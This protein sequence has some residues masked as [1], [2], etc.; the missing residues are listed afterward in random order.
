MASPLNVGDIYLLGRLAFK[1][2]SA[3]SRG[4]KS[5]PQEFREVENQLYSLSAALQA[6]RNEIQNGLS[7]DS[8]SLPGAFK[9]RNGGDEDVVGRIVESCGETLKHLEAIVEKYS[10]IG[11][12]SDGSPASSTFRRWNEG[13]KSGWKAILWTK[14]GGDLMTLRSNLAVHTN[15]LNLLLGVIANS[16]ARRIETIVNDNHEMLHDIHTWFTKNL[17]NSSVT[18]QRQTTQ[19]SWTEYQRIE[20]FELHE[21]QGTG[22]Q[23]VCPLATINPDILSHKKSKAAGLFICHCVVP[24]SQVSHRARVDSFALS[25]LSI[26]TRVAGAERSFMLY[27][28]ADRTCGILK[29]LFV[30]NMA[31]SDVAEVEDLFQHLTLDQTAPL[32]C[33]GANNLL[34]FTNTS[35]GGPFRSYILNLIADTRPYKRTIGSV[36]FRSSSRRSFYERSDVEA[37]H[38]LH[39][40]STDSDV[41]TEQ[42]GEYLFFRYE[43]H[44]EIQLRYAR[45]PHSE[46]TDIVRTTLNL[47]H[48][49]QLHSDNAQKSITFEDISCVGYT[50]V[51]DANPAGDVGVTIHFST[52]ESCTSF[53]KKVEEMQLELFILTLQYPISVERTLWKLQAH[54]VYT[55]H[56][57]VADAE[58]SILEN[59]TTARFRLT[60][61]SRDGLT[62]IS[63][64]L[65]ETFLE[66]LSSASK[67]S[68]ENPTFVVQ[69]DE[70]GIRRVKNYAR[71]FNVLAFADVT[72]EH[73]FRLGLDSISTG[74][75]LFSM[76]L[77]K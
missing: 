64:E 11:R 21:G 15:S 23:L 72:V 71:G 14:E 7:L 32:I 76:D 77:E 73:L 61:T 20:T 4:R 12:S 28:V 43:D 30:K 35:E 54:T 36:T 50:A 42:D 48:S 55:E 8:S 16:Q 66:S 6:F 74:E 29:T 53:R 46:D 34:C 1:L 58:V 18:L 60:I 13:I 26:C 37:V 52:L 69:L 19:T 67:I 56:F 63:Q 10:N 62:V 47:T 57:Q 59:T 27:K 65:P 70:S 31:R 2:G 5:A 44:A 45:A 39:Y 40:K 41:F 17:E 38:I 24:G 68:F 22:S 51:G 3:F 33:Q 75:R 9:A 25:P 49:T